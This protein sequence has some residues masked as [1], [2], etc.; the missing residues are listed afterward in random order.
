MNHDVKALDWTCFQEYGNPS[1]HSMFAALLTEFILIELI[2]PKLKNALN[3]IVCTCVTLILIVLT[4]ISRMFLGMHAGNQVLLGLIIGF[5][6]ILCYR[7]Y[8]KNVIKKMIL[9]IMEYNKRK[10]YRDNILLMCMAYAVFIGIVILIF[11]L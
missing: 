6:C 9:K 11:Y 2:F 4:V 7:F 10:M 8:L 5:Y 1:G 3:K